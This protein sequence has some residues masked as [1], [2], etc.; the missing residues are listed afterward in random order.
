VASKRKRRR[1]RSEEVLGDSDLVQR[2]I[3]RLEHYGRPDSEQAARL[4]GTP[5]V[6]G[7]P[8]RAD[9]VR[10]LTD[11][12]REYGFSD[13]ADVLEGAIAQDLRTVPLTADEREDIL[14][15]LVVAPHGLQ[16]LRAVLRQEHELR[17]RERL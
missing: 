3:E 14:R 5:M 10:I 17:R 15:S 8:V 6:A 11:L 16:E 2:L 12:V 13:T 9:D 1:E 4:A 7:V